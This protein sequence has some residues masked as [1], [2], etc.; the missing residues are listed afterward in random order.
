VIVGCGI[1][2]ADLMLFYKGEVELEA[3]TD[4]FTRKISFFAVGRLDH[5][6]ALL[7]DETRKERAR[8]PVASRPRK[9]PA[10]SPLRFPFFETGSPPLRLAF[11]LSGGRSFVALLRTFLS[12]DRVCISVALVC[13]REKMA[14]KETRSARIIAEFEAMV[15]E[16]V[17][18]GVYIV[19]SH[20]RCTNLPSFFFPVGRR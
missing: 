8:A 20:E 4:D 15:K 9:K 16:G 1:L 3:K 10:F 5:I 19:P 13:V 11:L 7:C 14:A 18:S 17:P 12:L 2:L 6:S